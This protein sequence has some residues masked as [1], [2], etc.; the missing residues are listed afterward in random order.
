[1]PYKNKNKGKIYKKKYAK[2]HKIEKAIYDKIYYNK[3]K[4]KI[5][6]QM[7]KYY[8][9]HKKEI[10]KHQKNRYEIYKEK[11]PYYNSYN[12]AKERCNNSKDKSYNYYGGKGIKCLITIEEMNY[13]WFRDKA[14]LMKRPSI[15]RINSKN[16]YTLKNCRF[17]ELNKNI[18][19]ANK[20]RKK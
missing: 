20:G 13:L 12:G 19:R 8:E 3:N 18:S 6:K 5:N 10:I 11:Y 9:E 17:I 2:E 7:K 16:N 15:D 1:M 4:K 14:Y